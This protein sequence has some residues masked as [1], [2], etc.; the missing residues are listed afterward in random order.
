[1]SGLSVGFLLHDRE[2][3]KVFVEVCSKPQINFLLPVS[4]ITSGDFFHFLPFITP[5][6]FFRRGASLHLLTVAVFGEA[7]FFFHYNIS[8]CILKRAAVRTERCFLN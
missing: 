6:A 3:G 5:R 7:F 2:A 8:N 4:H 1:M